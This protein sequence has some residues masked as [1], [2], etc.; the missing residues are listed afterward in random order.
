MAL[1]WKRIAF[2]E[3]VAAQSVLGNPTGSPAVATPI[4]VAE[5][6][7]LGRITGGNVDDLSVAQVKTLLGVISDTAYASSWNGVTDVAPSKNAVYDEMELRAPKISPIFTAS[8]PSEATLGDNLVTNGDF[9][10]NDL[11]GWTAAAGWSAATG[12]AV[13]TAGIGD[14]TPLVQ[15]ISLTNDLMYMVEVTVSGRTAGSVV[16]SFGSLQGNLEVFVDSVRK[17]SFTATSTASFNLTLTPTTDFDGAVDDILVREITANT[18]PIIDINDS[19]PTSVMP[20]RAN[21]SNYN[22]GIGY[23]ALAYNVAGNNNTAFG[24][25]ALATAPVAKFCTAF[26]FKALYLNTTGYYNVALGS[27]SLGKN[28]IG[29]NN[30]AIGHAA[31]YE[32]VV[33]SLN[34]GIGA[35]AGRYYGSGTGANTTSSYSTFIGAFTRA[36]ADGVQNECVIGY[37]AVGNGSNTVTIGNTSVTGW[38][39]GATKLIGV[40]GAAVA[41]ATGAGDVVA[42]LN[43]LLARIRAHGLIAT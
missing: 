13:H 1:V 38:Y 33:G 43:A 39:M 15:T 18:T 2:V 16:I 17:V 7:L 20:F 14:T 37:N 12:K 21:A 9:A 6:T 40:R 4:T 25:Q 8:A 10:T 26:G 34:I 24:Y 35:S 5:Q 28:T 30:M 41:D 11:T 22:I 42:Q 29:I 31:L 23:Q 36:S 3:D 19:T 27:Q 32:N